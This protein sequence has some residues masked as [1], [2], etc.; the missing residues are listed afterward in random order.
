MGMGSGM[1]DF[2]TAE[3]GAMAYAAPALTIYG[4]V[5]DLTA[6][7]T[8]ITKESVTGQGANRRCSADTNRGPC[9]L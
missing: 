2:T 6:S 1:T 8:A 9:Q 3:R 5:V 4:S 7:G